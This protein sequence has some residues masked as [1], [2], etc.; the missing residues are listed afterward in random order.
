M[1]RDWDGELESW[2]AEQGEMLACKRRFVEM[3][4]YLFFL[5]LSPTCKQCLGMRPSCMLA[6][7]HH[8]SGI[9]V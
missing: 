1:K 3:P 4:C 5:L 6:S 9:Q 2:N 8:N 7:D